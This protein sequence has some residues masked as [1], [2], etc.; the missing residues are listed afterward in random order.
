MYQT[1]V[2]DKATFKVL[3]RALLETETLFSVSYL[4]YPHHNWENVVQFPVL[5]VTA[6]AKAPKAGT[7]S[8]CREPDEWSYTPTPPYTFMAFTERTSCLQCYNRDCFLEHHQLSQLRIE[9]MVFCWKAVISQIYSVFSFTPYF[10]LT[11]TVQM[12]PLN[13]H[14]HL[15]AQTVLIPQIQDRTASLYSE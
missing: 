11:F 7:P 13:E 9:N 15:R 6:F 5:H 3:I 4:R 10:S 14:T 2:F 12:R 1:F 8:A